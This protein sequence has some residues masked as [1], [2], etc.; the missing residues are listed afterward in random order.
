MRTEGF[1][2]FITCFLFAS[3]SAA[4][5]KDE[6]DKN[7]AVVKLKQHI[8]ELKVYVKQQNANT[9]YAILIDMNIPAWENRFFVVNLVTDS[10]LF[11][12]KVCHGQGTTMSRIEVPVSN[13]VGSN[14]T[15]LGRYAIG[16]KYNGKFGLSYKL[17]GLDSTNSNAYKRY[18][19]FHSFAG[20]DEMSPSY[21]IFSDGCPTVSPKVLSATAQLLDASS[22]PLMMWIYK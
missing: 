10:I 21:I 9:K 4:P 12:G 18:V 8:R 2:F 19:V 11:S 14:C 3:C 7:F 22:K 1:S 13:V 20:V 16:E 15:S 5:V 6:A 17:H